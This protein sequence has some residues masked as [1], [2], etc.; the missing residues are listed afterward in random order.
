MTELKEPL[1]EET[2]IKVEEPIKKRRTRKRYKCK[3]CEKTMK[4]I[5]HI[6]YYGF[7]NICRSEFEEEEKTLIINDTNSDLIKINYL[8]KQIQVCSYKGL[9]GKKRGYIRELNNLVN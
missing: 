4:K 1:I 7:C 5:E 8:K 9:Y 2:E 3:K 6:E